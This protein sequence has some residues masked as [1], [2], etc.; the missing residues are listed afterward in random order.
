[1]RE[2]WG[3]TEVGLSA[4]TL[5]ELVHG[6]QRAKLEEQRRRRDA[7]VEELMTTVTVH[8][9]IAE[10]ARLAGRISGQSAA[11]GESYDAF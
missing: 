8:P 11:R 2:A 5:V 1:M 6:V 4:V 3:E 10:I 9:V 7:F